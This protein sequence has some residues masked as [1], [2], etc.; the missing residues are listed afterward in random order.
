MPVAFFLAG[1]KPEPERSGCGEEKNALL[2][3]RMKRRFF[4][5]CEATSPWLTLNLI[6][7]AF[8]STNWECGGHRTLKLTPNPKMATAFIKYLLWMFHVLELHAFVVCSR[9]VRTIWHRCSSAA[10]HLRCTKFMLITDLS[11]LIA[12]SV[13]INTAPCVV[14]LMSG[15]SACNMT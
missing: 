9:T 5:R 4:L 14:R 13:A 12:A 8:S 1:W 11:A 15:V 7:E 3:S 2:V 6:V 10:V